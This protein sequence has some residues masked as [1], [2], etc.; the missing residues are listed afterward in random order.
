MRWWKWIGLGALA[1]VAVAG[2]TAVVVRQRRTWVDADD[3]EI[4]E[5]LR[6][7]LAELRSGGVRPRS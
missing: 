3:T 5:R 7:R 4:A 6:G 1:A 2:A